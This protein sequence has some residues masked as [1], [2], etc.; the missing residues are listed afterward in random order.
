[1]S[2]VFVSPNGSDSGATLLV[3]VLIIAVLIGGVFA[4]SNGWFM[5]GAKD[6]NTEINV[7]VP[8][9]SNEDKVVPTM[10]ETSVTNY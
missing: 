3:I 10:G 8:D 5:N 4:Y 7:T 2:E 6:E 1:M 9:S